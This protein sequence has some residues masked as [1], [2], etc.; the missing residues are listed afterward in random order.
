VFEVA[1]I[2]EKGSGRLMPESGLVRD[3][4]VQIGLP[5]ELYTPKR[6]HRRQLPLTRRCFVFGD[7]DCMHGAMRQLKIPIPDAVYFPPSL[8][9]YLH[10]K[11]WLDTLGNVRKRIEDGAAAVFAKPASRAKVFTGQIFSNHSDFYHVAQT[12]WR[13]PVWCSEVVAWQSEYRVYVN[14]NDIVSVDYYAGDANVVLNLNVAT[15]AVA[16]YARSGEAPAA[17]GIDFGVLASGETALVEANDGYALGA[18][19]ISS[20]AYTQL[21]FVRWRQLLASPQGD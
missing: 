18:Y 8:T 1:F 11:I 19:Q 2:Q 7:M 20:T 5:I 3:H 6:I 17:F 9:Q 21:M 12:S 13:E 10:R 16:L 4:C 15:H 14:G